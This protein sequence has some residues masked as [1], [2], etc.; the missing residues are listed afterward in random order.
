MIGFLASPGMILR[1]TNPRFSACLLFSSISPADFFLSRLGIPTQ[2]GSAI[3]CGKRL[4]GSSH[5]GKSNVEVTRKDRLGINGTEV[6]CFVCFSVLL[7]VLKEFRVL[8]V[9]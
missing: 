7:F 5:R 6:R 4:A 9:S 2:N 1:V 3:Q 8:F